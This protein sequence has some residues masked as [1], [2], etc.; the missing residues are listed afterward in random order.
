MKLRQIFFNKLVIRNLIIFF[1]VSILAGYVEFHIIKNMPELISNI[2]GKNSKNEI[3]YLI[4]SVLLLPLRLLGLKLLNYTARSINKVFDDIVLDSIDKASCNKISQLN[5]DDVRLN[6]VTNSYDLLRFIIIPTLSAIYALISSLFLYAGVLYVNRNISFLI[7]GILI[8]FYF[9]SFSI[10]K[11]S[12]KNNSKNLNNSLEELDKNVREYADNLKE[13]YLYNLNKI[14]NKK[15]T[16]T[17]KKLYS[18]YTNSIFSAR[19][20]RNLLD[21][22]IIVFIASIVI[23]ININ[24]EG[25]EDLYKSLIAVFIPIGYSF[26][27]LIILSQQ[28]FN[29]TVNIFNYKH[30]YSSLKK[31]NKNLLKNNNEELN[32]KFITFNTKKSNI[33]DLTITLKDL[34]SKY[35]LSSLEKGLNLVFK[36]PNLY[37][38]KGLSGA[39]KTT[40]LE[41]MIGFKET[42]YGE[43]EYNLQSRNL[44][45]FRESIAY[46]SQYPI[47]LEGSI[48]ENIT[49][50]KSQN[51]D[52]KSLFEAALKAG[53]FP[54][55]ILEKVIDEKNIFKDNENLIRSFLQKNVGRN[56]QFLSGGERKRVS[57]ARAIYSK[58]PI[59]IFDEPTSGLDEK[60]ENYIVDS[61][62]E[63]R[64]NRLIIISTHSNKFNENTNKNIY[65]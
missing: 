59:L 7:I 50:S 28:T 44:L 15:I 2:S 61:L 11:N 60:F 65:L 25:S 62:N 48:E 13:V 39:G 24:Y 63:L 17:R 9:I 56:G 27:R 26:Q 5:P 3:I 52:R 34:K 38:I 30:Y 45:K 31:F 54:K 49:L 4:F 47:L 18:T 40:F 22:L 8:F 32:P 58:R 12:F 21:W 51:I 57:I 16:K 64:K 23:I 53:C 6:L 29:C 35:I 14:L 36:F 10:I 19:L 42:E 1:I 55:T 46:A 33:F 37:L 20:T 41:T 43:I